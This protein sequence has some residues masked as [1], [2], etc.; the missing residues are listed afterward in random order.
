MDEQYEFM[1]VTESLVQRSECV[2]DEDEGGGPLHPDAHRV[3]V[4]AAS[5]LIKEEDAPYSV[6]EGD[7]P[8]DDRRE[9]LLGFREIV[10]VQDIRGG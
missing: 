9:I 10:A 2:S 3:H 5:E 1:E 4:L 7:D 8:W 6:V